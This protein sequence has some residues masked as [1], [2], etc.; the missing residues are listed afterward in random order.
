[1][2]LGLRFALNL[3]A[4]TPIAATI[5]LSTASLLEK[6]ESTG[7]LS[8]FPIYVLFGYLYAIL[9]SLA[10]AWWLHRRYRAG[11]DPR[12]RRSVT[13]S[14]ASGLCAGLII[15]CMFGSLGGLLMFIALG[16]ATGALNGLL[17]FLI[18]AKPATNPP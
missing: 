12:S 1:M 16:A 7:A 15:G 2:K 5:L 8:W 13:L 14:T 18:R 3:L 9:P 10:H 11:L 6:G 4:P 17:H